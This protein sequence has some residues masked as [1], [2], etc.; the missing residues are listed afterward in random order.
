MSL[1]AYDSSS[2]ATGH[3]AGI[4]DVVRAQSHT[5]NFVIKLGKWASKIS[6]HFSDDSGCG[7]YSVTTIQGKQNKKLSIIAAYIVV[8]KGSDNG[9][10]SVYAQQMTIHEHNNLKH[11]NDLRRPFS[12]RTDTIHR[13]NILIQQLQAQH[14][15]I[16]LTIDA[17]QSYAECYKALQL[18]TH[19]I[20]WLCLQ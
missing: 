2:V 15:A 13:L 7:S 8:A 10:E 16:V 11:P 20:E 1:H 17:N 6:N 3:V 14:Y 5:S 19:S 18:C 4:C 12:P 9:I